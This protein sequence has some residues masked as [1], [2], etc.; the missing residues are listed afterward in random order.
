MIELCTAFLEARFDDLKFLTHV[1]VL[2]VTNITYTVLIP[3]FVYNCTVCAGI[4]QSVLSIHK[5]LLYLRFKAAA[6]LN[7]N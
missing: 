7:Q 4:T 6:K 1:H 2:H 5:Q 3:S